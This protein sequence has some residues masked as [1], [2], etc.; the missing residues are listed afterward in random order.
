[1]TKVAGKT[2][3]VTGGAMG[4]GRLHAERALESG[5]K[6][7]ILW[8]ANEE[9]LAK[10]CGE[11][12]ARGGSVESTVVD[13][14][15]A[16]AIEFAAK[17]TLDAHG[18]VHV[19]I[20]NAGVV[21]PGAFLDQTTQEIERVIQI[22]LLGAM[23]VARAFLESMRALPEA[24]LVNIS[25]ASALMPLPYGAVYAASKWAVY[26][27][28]ESL[29]LELAD[30][31]LNHIRV[32]T[33][34][35]SFVATGMFEGARSPRF[36]RFLKPIEVI[37]DAWRGMDRNQPVVL[38][39]LMTHTALPMRALLPRAAFDWIARRFFGVYDAMKPLKGRA[40]QSNPPPTEQSLT[41]AESTK[42]DRASSAS[43]IPAADDSR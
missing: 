35:P 33:V 34:C 19:L 20:N 14:S 5:A 22:N 29:R 4:M 1:M 10:T 39:P 2:V 3:L 16:Q 40:T 42:S 23:H 38:T 26:C 21:V 8:D 31:G 27:W 15:D 17:E 7:V 12:G 32:T 11:L 37:D 25:S 28:S 13:V 6:R 24:H 9:A 36:T 30:M 18:P 43:R 41:V